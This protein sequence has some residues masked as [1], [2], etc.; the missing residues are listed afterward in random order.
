MSLRGA[1]RRG[2]LVQ[3]LPS[4]CKPVRLNRL[5]LRSLRGHVAALQELMQNRPYAK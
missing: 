3:E 5:P 4:A 2:N 1:Q